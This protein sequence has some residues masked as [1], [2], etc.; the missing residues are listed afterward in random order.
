MNPASVLSAQV[1]AKPEEIN[2]VGQ[3][4]GEVVARRLRKDS[5]NV[6]PDSCSRRRSAATCSSRVGVAAADAG[7]PGSAGSALLRT[8]RNQCGGS[9]RAAPVAILDRPA[10]TDHPVRGD[11]ATEADEAVVNRH[12]PSRSFERSSPRQAMGTDAGVMIERMCRRRKDEGNTGLWRGQAIGRAE[13]D[14]VGPTRLHWLPGGL[15]EFKELC[16]NFQVARG[17]INANHAFRKNKEQPAATYSAAVEGAAG[18]TPIGI[19]HAPG[20]QEV[21]VTA[22]E[23]FPDGSRSSSAPDERSAVRWRRYIS[24]SRMR[25]RG[26]PSSSSRRVVSSTNAFGPQMKHRAAWSRTIVASSSWPIRLAG[27]S[28]ARGRA[29]G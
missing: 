3:A 15:E 8:G 21:M 28:T 11:S 5:T 16:G 14:V 25:S 7:G 19:P 20:P 29:S 22:A 9:F 26:I 17:N 4:T 23:E 12:R 2:I 1:A 18:L 6:M 27:L 24:S 13:N 10:H